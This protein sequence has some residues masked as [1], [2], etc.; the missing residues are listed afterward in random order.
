M[1]ISRGARSESRPPRQ[2]ARY[3][4]N[5]HSAGAPCGG[6][7]DEADRHCG[8]N[9]APPAHAL[10]TRSE[11][12]EGPLDGFAEGT[13]GGGLADSGGVHPGAGAPGHWTGDTMTPYYQDDAVTLYCGDCRDILPQIGMVDHVITDPPY[14]EETHA[15]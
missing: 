15:G 13:V 2:E 11:N 3:L 1:S 7:E 6:G 14:A 10:L 12:R 5:R 8:F 4:R 9:R